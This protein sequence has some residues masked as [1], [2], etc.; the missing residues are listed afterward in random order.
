MWIKTQG[1]YLIN[2]DNLE[3]IVFDADNNYTYGNTGN[4]AHIIGFG[5]VTTII[6]DNIQRGSA[7]MEVK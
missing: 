5:D 2:S 1:G 6:A 3:F 7:F 4:Y